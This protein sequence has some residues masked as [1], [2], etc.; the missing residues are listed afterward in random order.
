MSL[1]ISFY[2]HSCCAAGFFAIGLPEGPS[3]LT[4]ALGVH[5]V[6]SPPEKP[7]ITNARPLAS[8]HSDQWAYIDQAQKCETKCT[9]NCRT[10]QVFLCRLLHK[11]LWWYVPRPLGLLSLNIWLHRIVEKPTSFCEVNVFRKEYPWES[12]HPKV[13]WLEFSHYWTLLAGIFVIGLVL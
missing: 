5:C 9:N 2:L 7:K 6:P 8:V 1:H 3:K 12:K 11:L 10:N 4:E 13:S